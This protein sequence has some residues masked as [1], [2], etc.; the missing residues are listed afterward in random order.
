MSTRGDA[1]RAHAEVDRK[2]TKAMLQ[3]EIQRLL[4]LNS[5]WKDGRNSAVDG[6]REAGLKVAQLQELLRQANVRE[7]N[8]NERV[9]TLTVEVQTLKAAADGERRGYINALRIVSGEGKASPIAGI[10]SELLKS[11]KQEFG[12]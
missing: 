12:E 5:E 3:A 8:L 7:V 9:T 10:L 11:F 1:T 4:K 2:T 6:C